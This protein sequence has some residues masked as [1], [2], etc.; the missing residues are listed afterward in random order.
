VPQGTAL[1]DS[2]FTVPSWVIAGGEP[3]TTNDLDRLGGK[4][5]VPGV[6]LAPHGKGKAAGVSDK[7][8]AMIRV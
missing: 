8:S 6:I 1:K 3:E 2:T 4:L 5:I 7:V